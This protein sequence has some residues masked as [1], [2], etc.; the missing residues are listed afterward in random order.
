M[1]TFTRRPFTVIELDRL[2]DVTRNR[3]RRYAETHPRATAET[4]ER[5]RRKGEERASPLVEIP[6]IVRISD[7]EV[8][9]FDAEGRFLENYNTPEDFNRASELAENSDGSHE[10]SR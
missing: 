5:F 1:Q 6:G 7:A 3:W 9:S 8:R 2:D 10:S 4:I